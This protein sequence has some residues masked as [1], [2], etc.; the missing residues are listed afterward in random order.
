MAYKFL[1]MG[2]KKWV[3]GSCK[4]SLGKGS[5]KTPSLWCHVCG[6]IHFKCSGLTDSKEYH[7]NFLCS[8]CRESRVLL[9]DEKDGDYAAAFPKIHDHYTNPGNTS[10]F[11]SRRSLIKASKFQPQDVDRYLNSSETY[12]KFKL[13]RKRFPR[14]KVISY[15]LNEIWSID[16]ADMQKLANTNAGIRYLFVAVDVLSRYLWVEPI[17]VKT[18]HACR[19]ALKKIFAKNDKSRNP[20]ICRETHQPEKIWVDKGR[21]FSGEF[22]TFCSQRGIEIY[23]TKSET[24]SALAERNIRSLKSLIFKYMHEHD[25]SRYFDKLDQFVAIINNRVNRM[26]KLAPSSVSQKDVNYLVSLCHTNAQKKPKFR[27]GQQVRIRRKIDTFHRG[28]KI[29]FT[30][31]L[32]KIAAIPTNNPPTYIVKDCDGEIIQGK[33]YEPELVRFAPN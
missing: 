15:R 9:D 18:A 32:F 17:K 5:K 20:K 33:F 12:T 19:E 13:T 21:E 22:A 1:K 29:Q 3:C 14:L 30:E 28:Y 6:W 8:H 24:K 31:K 16:L 25:Q 4:K 10:A 2:N 23:S 11:G 26:T 7:D 27:I